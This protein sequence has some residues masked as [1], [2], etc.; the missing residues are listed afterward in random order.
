MICN[1]SSGDDR[2]V[3]Q[4]ALQVSPWNHNS[5]S[6]HRSTVED[7]GNMS[8]GV[9]LLHSAACLLETGLRVLSQDKV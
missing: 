4:A 6:I 7:D 2:Q 3:D 9:M 5:C 1:A 8:E